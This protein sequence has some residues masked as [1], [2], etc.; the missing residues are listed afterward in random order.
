MVDKNKSN[1]CLGVDVF[2]EST[3]P[4]FLLNP[5]KI[6]ETATTDVVWYNYPHIYYL[7]T[8]AVIIKE[9][10]DIKFFYFKQFYGFNQKVFFLLICLSATYS[11]VLMK[12]WGGH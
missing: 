3:S 10:W 7:C 8:E 6:Y 9:P 1:G 12:V 2:I 4:H 11:S 5:T